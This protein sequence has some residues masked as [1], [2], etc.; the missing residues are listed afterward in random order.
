MT[1]EY[2]ILSE[3]DIEKHKKKYVHYLEIIIEENG[4]VVYAVPSHQE[5]MIKLA[6]NKLRISRNE[7][8]ALCP[9]E[10]YFDYLRWL[11]MQ[12]GAIAVWEDAYIGDKL[13]KKQISM[14]KKLKLHGLYKGILPKIGEKNS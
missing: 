8:G 14:L 2:S 6:C 4:H 5:R 7:L 11:S 12:S 9:R 13:S 3:F 1:E 10:Y